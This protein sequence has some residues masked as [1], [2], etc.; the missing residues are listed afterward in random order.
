LEVWP[1]RESIAAD[2]IV[3][4][5]NAA[6]E[7]AAKAGGYDA[8]VS[9]T[10]GRGDATQ[11]ETEVHSFDFLEP[12]TDGFRNYVRKP[13]MPIEDHL[14]DRAQLLTLSAPEMT[15]LVGGLR[16]LQVGDDKLGVLITRPGT[17]SNDYFVNLLDMGV[18]WSAAGGDNLFEGGPKT[19]QEMDRHA[20]RPHLWARTHSLSTGG[21][22]QRQRRE[23]EVRDGLRRRLSNL[24]N[25]DQFDLKK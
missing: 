21:S 16:A 10:P 22:L 20:R 11:E 2:L 18:K 7:K 19:G 6:V 8:K 1:A 14:V 3:I 23:E 12:K 15:V 5:G 13:I 25:L 17:L 9:F 24:M 4:A